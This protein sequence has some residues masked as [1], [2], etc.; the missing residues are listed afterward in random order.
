MT[1]KRFWIRRSWTGLWWVA[2]N[3]D[4][5]L[6]EFDC[7]TYYRAWTRDRLIRKLRRK[8]TPK[9]SPWREITHGEIR[10]AE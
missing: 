4:E 9:P 2:V 10:G 5:T 7:S 8:I 6:A 1:E 3:P